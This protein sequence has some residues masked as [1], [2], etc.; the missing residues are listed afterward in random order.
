MLYP[1]KKRWG[2]LVLWLVMTGAATAWADGGVDSACSLT[3]LANF[4]NDAFFGDDR[5]YTTGFQLR[6]I[7]PKLYEFSFGQ[8]IYT[9]EDKKNPAYL[10]DDRPYAGYLYGTFAMHAAFGPAMDTWELALGVIGPSSRG[11][12][13]QNSFHKLIGANNAKGWSHQLGDE[14]TAMLTWSR[15]LRLNPDASNHEGWGWDVLP[16]FTTSLGT[17]HTQAGLGAEF[18]TGWNLPNDFSSP[19]TRPGTGV[20][21]PTDS[22][23]KGPRD[24]AFRIYFF[25]GAGGKAVLWNS[26][27]DGNLWKKSHSISKYPVVG[28]MNAGIVC[29]YGRLRLAC[30]HVCRTK[31]FH[32]Q[33]GSQNYGVVTVGW[34]F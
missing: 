12:Q 29:E 20:R 21:V 19:A 26:F 31:E 22:D 16:F 34:T 1:G 10:P 3:V 11:K 18:R 7:T 33:K 24:G 8:Q 32:G 4:E 25:A 27:L 14:F 15:A 23:S 2:L 5:Y 17:P 28:E 6:F 13:I 9:P 30:T